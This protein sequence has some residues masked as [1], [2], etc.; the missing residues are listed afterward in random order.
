MFLTDKLPVADQSAAPPKPPL[1]IVIFPDR[2][3]ELLEIRPR[4]TIDRDT[5]LEIDAFLR[6][7]PRPG[8]RDQV[9]GAAHICE[10]HGWKQVDAW[11]EERT[12]G[13]KDLNIKMQKEPK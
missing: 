13:L 7:K 3:T 1:E 11:T 10:R 9:L 2:V 4:G 12:L 6:Q 8:V 5:Y